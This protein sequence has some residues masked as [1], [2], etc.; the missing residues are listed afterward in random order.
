MINSN[1]VNSLIRLGV[2]TLALFTFYK[3]SGKTTKVPNVI[4]SASQTERKEKAI[5]LTTFKKHYFSSKQSPDT[6][7]MVL[8]G[9]NLTKAVVTFT[10]LNPKGMVIYTVTFPAQ[11]LI[12]Y[13]IL[14]EN[15]TRKQ[16]E[17]VIK[18]RVKE[19]FL[20]K[21]FKSPAITADEEFEE[22]YAE[23]SIWQDIKSDKTAIGFYY[24]IGEED[25]RWIAYSKKIKKV[26]V[27]HNCC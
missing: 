21:N 7:R 22:D 19:F 17:D 25:M 18:R 20:D 2:F 13:E 1:T 4:H 26:V 14:E 3:V 10:I 5:L 23:K 9:E 11:Y 12:G 15:P 6:F 8:N 16:Q 27:Y 24:L